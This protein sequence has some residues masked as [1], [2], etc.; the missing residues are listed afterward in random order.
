MLKL[1]TKARTTLKL[2]AAFAPPAVLSQCGKVRGCQ[3]EATV[4][5]TRMLNPSSPVDGAVVM[6]IVVT[7]EME[8]LLLLL[9][10][11]VDQCAVAR[12]AGD[13]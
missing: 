9:L 4:E 6:G 3:Y 2:I 12:R 11:L 10:L 13:G 1:M 5:C 7:K 8:V